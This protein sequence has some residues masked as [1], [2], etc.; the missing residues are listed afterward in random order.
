VTIFYYGLHSAEDTA[1]N[2]AGVFWLKSG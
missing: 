2:A 1:A